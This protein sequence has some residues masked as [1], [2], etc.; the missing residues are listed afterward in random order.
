[1]RAK[2]QVFPR[3]I[4]I[5]CLLILSLVATGCV[6]SVTIEFGSFGT[7]Q[8]AVWFDLKSDED[9]A[10]Y[11]VLTTIPNYC[12]KAQEIAE[13]ANNILDNWE[14]EVDGY[15]RHGDDT[16]EDLAEL[17]A[18]LYSNGVS[19]N[20]N[21]SVYDEGEQ[22]IPASGSISEDD[23]EDEE[24]DLYLTFVTGN[25][26]SLLASEWSV[27]DCGVNWSDVADNAPYT[28]ADR[29][30]LLTITK[31]NGKTISGD[32][33]G[34]LLDEDEDKA[35]DFEVSFSAKHCPIDYS[36]DYISFWP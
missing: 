36:D 12:Q 34:E 3:Q 33:V 2:F 7:V 23:R 16:Y 14:E 35:G 29:D 27:N 1:M 22:E 8:S 20:M 19:S 11:I 18:A 9:D 21:I 15:C 5:A 30:S 26:Y 17:T 10:E 31:N 25:Y 13:Q 4:K 24:F 6:G 28:Y 32:I